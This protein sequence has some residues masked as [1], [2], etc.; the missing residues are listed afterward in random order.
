MS[1]EN[2]K[3]SRVDRF[4]LSNQLR[5]LEALNPEEAHDIAVQREALERGYE[6]LYEWGMDHIYDGDDAMTVEESTEVWDT[7]DMFDAINRAAEG[8]GTA[9]LQENSFAKFRGYD[10]NNETKFMTFAAFTMQRLQRFEKVPMLKPGY[11]NSHMPMRQTY[12]RMLAE[13]RKVPT[14]RR[15]ELTENELSTVLNAH[16]HPNRR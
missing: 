15:F 16:V 6:M 13:W 10:G 8:L 1:S 3:L 11:W 9:E 7:L 4:L 2:T 14:E 5:I 12:N